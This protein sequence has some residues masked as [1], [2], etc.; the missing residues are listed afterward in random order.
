MKPLSAALALT[1]A[2]GIASTAPAQ[3][4]ISEVNLTPQSGSDDR[5]IELRNVGPNKVDL[6][7]W[8]IYLA[9]KT[10]ARANNYWF[11]FPRGTSVAAGAFLR[12]HWFAPVQASTATDIWTGDTVFH[13]L[14]GYGAEPLD[15]KSGAL[16][17]LSS[18]QNIDMN[19]PRFY[20]DWVSWGE[21]AQKRESIAAQAGQ[22]V[23]NSFVPA[24]EQ[25]DSIAWISF[26]DASPTPVAAWF[27][28][29]SPTPLADNHPAA[30]LGE[31]GS[32]CGEG[33]V[34]APALVASSVATPGNQDFGFRI[35]GTTAG[36]ITVLMLAAKAGNGSISIGNCKIWI[37]IVPTPL[38]L[39]VPSSTPSTSIPLPMPVSG[40]TGFDVYAQAAVLKPASF[41]DYGFTQG[42]RVTVGN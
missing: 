6:D 18:Q 12:V 26:R 2:T 5:W 37:E 40:L 13:F 10:P 3:V 23:L 28:D 41:F 36:Q 8:T 31:Y 19:D 11:G 38:I 35:D 7:T 29:R 42:V 4:V 15:P 20:R 32:N 14:F 1:L 39:N 21:G 22:W 27:R 30:A 16:A 17:L 33:S 9:T 25:K 34:P 24:P